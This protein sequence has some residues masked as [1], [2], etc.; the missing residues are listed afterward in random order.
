MFL[1]RLVL[2]AARSF[3]TA[4]VVCAL[5]LFSASLVASA[6]VLLLVGL[7]LVPIPAALA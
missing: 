1:L 4:G 2:G 7:L 5:V 6:V 3:Q